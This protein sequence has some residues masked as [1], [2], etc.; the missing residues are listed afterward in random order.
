MHNMVALTCMRTRGLLAGFMLCHMAKQGMG[1]LS[2]IH[3][4][5]E[6]VVNYSVPR[7]RN[8]QVKYLNLSAADVGA[9]Q[10]RNHWWLNRIS[11][12]AGLLVS[13]GFSHFCVVMCHFLCLCWKAVYMHVSCAS[14]IC[15][16]SPSIGVCDKLAIHICRL[17]A[18]IPGNIMCCHSRMHES[19]AQARG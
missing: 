14:C 6:P 13:T 9:P 4:W 19:I 12:I 5:A 11:T 17:Q 1:M 2:L 15:M 3:N 16:Y 7:Q 18:W 8:F 10:L